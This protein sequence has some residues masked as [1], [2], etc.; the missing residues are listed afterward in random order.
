MQDLLESLRGASG[1]DDALWQGVARTL[2]NL[3]QTITRE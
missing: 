3:E 2:L 1:S